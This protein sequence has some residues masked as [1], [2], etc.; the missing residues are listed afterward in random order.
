MPVNQIVTAFVEPG[1]PPAAG[2]VPTAN[3]SG[4]N[5]WQAPGA[6]QSVT[7]GSGITVGGTAANPVVTNAS[8][9]S[10]VTLASAGGATLVKTGAGPAL[11]AKGLTAGAGISLAQ[12]ANDVAVT[13][14]SPASSVALTSA[15]GAVSLVA[16]GAGPAL[17]VAGLTAGAG[18]SLVAAAGAVTVA[19]TSPASSVTLGSAGG[20]SLVKAGAG[21]AL[22]VKGILSGPGISLTEN[23]DDITIVN[24]A[25][26]SDVTLESAGAGATV[27]AQGVG[28]GLQTKGLVAGANIEMTDDEVDVTVGLAPDLDGIDSINGSG[29]GAGFNLATEQ[30]VQVNGRELVYPELS[31]ATWVQAAASTT[32]AFGAN[33]TKALTIPFTDEAVSSAFAATPASGL[34]EFDPSENRQSRVHQVTCIYTVQPSTLL[35]SG[36]ARH[37]ISVNG[38]T[39]IPAGAGRNRLDF[40]VGAAL[41]PGVPMVLV[42]PV[43]LA[44]GDTLQLGCALTGGAQSLT[45]SGVYFYVG[46]MLIYSTP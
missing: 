32:I 21:P 3:G 8:P 2:T 24:L 7:A 10:S 14:T 46:G 27:V 43:A 4:S 41:A 19:N 30:Q 25:P 20:L 17:A 22:A 31:Y 11:V 5:Y 44:R 40:T 38:A 26:A 36:T 45:Y 13:N 37:F 1:V 28:P 39:A 34:L 29:A 35:A 9:A 12:N 42:A 6:V 16:A 33:E 15:G 18:V 23:A